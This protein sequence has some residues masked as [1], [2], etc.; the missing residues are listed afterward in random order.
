MDLILEFFVN[1]YLWFL[2]IS[3]ILI[4]GLI[5][6]V[7]DVREKR[8]PKLHFGNKDDLNDG[9]LENEDKSLVELLEEDG[10]DEEKIEINSNIKMGINDV[11]NKSIIK[12]ENELQDE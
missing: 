2:I 9:G 5:G 6:Y 4:F 7:V 8:T 10:Y 12:E 11:I 3:L 1:N